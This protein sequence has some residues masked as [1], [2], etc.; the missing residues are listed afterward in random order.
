MAYEMYTLQSD[1]QF[2]LDGKLSQ[3][4]T[5]FVLALLACEEGSNP[6]DINS[7]PFPEPVATRF[8]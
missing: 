3:L 1:R 5:R 2:G 8:L 7:S 4:K 6:I